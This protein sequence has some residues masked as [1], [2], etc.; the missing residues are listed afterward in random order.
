MA[1][2]HPQSTVVSAPLFLVQQLLHALLSQIARLFMAAIPQIAGQ[3]PLNSLKRAGA[4]GAGAGFVHLVGNVG[5]SEGP[6]PS[7][8]LVTSFQWGHAPCSALQAGGTPET[9]RA[10]GAPGLSQAQEQ[11]CCPWGNLRLALPQ[12]RHRWPGSCWVRLVVTACRHDANMEFS[13]H[14]TFDFCC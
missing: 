11:S 12:T 8:Q 1:K 4:G 2:L 13:A 9:T 14:L 5:S 7:L 10:Q 6:R 3:L